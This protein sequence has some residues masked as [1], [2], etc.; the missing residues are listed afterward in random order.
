MDATA[1]YFHLRVYR[2]HSDWKACQIIRAGDKNIFNVSDF[3]LLSTVAQKLVLSFFPAKILR[4]SFQ[5]SKTR[6][7]MVLNRLM[8][9]RR[10]HIAYFLA[11][12]TFRYL[13]CFFVHRGINAARAAPCWQN[14]CGILYEEYLRKEYSKKRR[15]HAVMVGRRLFFKYS[16]R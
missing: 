4:T 5:P 11:L 12:W 14:V 15:I 6:L 3:R 8:I 16:E 10:N 7:M 2:F 1:L 9:Q 13:S